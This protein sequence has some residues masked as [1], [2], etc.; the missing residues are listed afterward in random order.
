ME[1]IENKS[2]TGAILAIDDK[3]FI[4]CQ[5]INCTLIYSGG[6]FAWTNTKFENCRITLA[7]AAQRTAA[8]MATFGIIKPPLQ[9][10]PLT[11]TSGG[12]VN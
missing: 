2:D 10:V 1:L 11:Q 12:V 4:N 5:F 8:V 9:Q 6:D 7:G 3:N